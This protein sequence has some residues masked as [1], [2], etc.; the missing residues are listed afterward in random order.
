MKL[1]IRPDI[2]ALFPHAKLGVLVC[3]G[4]RNVEKSPD[5]LIIW[6]RE[7]ER[8]LS[9]HYATVDSLTGDAKIVDWREA[10]R[11]FGFKPGQHRCSVEALCRRVLQ[12]K[13]LPVISAVVDIYNTISVKHVVPV[14]GD[15]IDRVVG[16]IV[17]TLADGSERFV[18]LGDKVE[19]IKKGE[20]IYRDDEEVLCRSWNYRE[21]EKSKITPETSNLCLVVEGLEHTGMPV[22]MAVVQDLRTAMEKYCGGSYE[23]FFLEKDNLDATF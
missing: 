8:D 1:R 14:G 2:I 18:M 15:D 4:V 6:M 22:L 12:G 16:D 7:T 17:L 10:Y 3:R 23:A 5:E 21:S 20:V 13:G 9:T 11:K 19:P